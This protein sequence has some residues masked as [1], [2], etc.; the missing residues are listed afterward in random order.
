MIPGPAADLSHGLT[1]TEAQARLQQYG[2]NRVDERRQSS[3]LAFLRKFWAPVPWMLQAAI[4]L[5][6]FLGKN[7][8]AIIISVLLVFNAI[9]S[10]AQ[11]CRA[12]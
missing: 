7:T 2:P 1:A 11:E 5:Q 9:L 6:L 8:E 4:V 12:N 10:F 3:W